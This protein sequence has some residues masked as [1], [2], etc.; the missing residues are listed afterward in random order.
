[1]RLGLGVQIA[2]ASVLTVAGLLTI[3]SLLNL[4]G[5]DVG[6]DSD[7]LLTVRVDVPSEL[8]A[9]EEISRT[10]DE[11][12]AE[13]QTIP[14]VE[15]AALWAPHVPAQDTWHT[16]V[17]VYSRAD[18]QELSDM[19]LVRIHQVSAGA[20]TLLGLEF[21]EGRD[22]SPADHESGRRVALVSESAA[23]E[24]WGAEPDVGRRIKRWNHDEWSTVTGV[25]ADA[26]LAGRQGEGSDFTKDVFFLHDQDPQPYL[27][28]FM[29]ME[30]AAPGGV[31]ATEAAIRC[32]A[33]DLPVCAV[34][35]I[36]DILNDQE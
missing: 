27:V 25:V 19:P 32:A 10:A 7:R 18:L 5:A 24:W 15:Q 17:A 28:F 20:A 29:R 3:R 35:F 26:P 8:C 1:V 31:I 23:R 33:P 11:I 9:V 22:F 6:F 30:D 4:V 13:I 21:K 34:R 12:L 16:S 2:L 14:V 36:K